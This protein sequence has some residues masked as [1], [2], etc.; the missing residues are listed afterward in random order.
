MACISLQNDE[1]GKVHT[2]YFASGALTT[3]EV[4]YRDLNKLVVALLF[5]CNKFKHF[6]L[7]SLGFTKV[8][9]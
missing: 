3:T 5:E 4:K 2:I 7:A 1:G 9:C 8:E 6:L